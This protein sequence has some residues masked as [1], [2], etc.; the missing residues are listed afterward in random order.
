MRSLYKI[1][2]IALIFTLIRVPLINQDTKTVKRFHVAA[3]N[4][5]AEKLFVV[6]NKERL[7]ELRPPWEKVLTMLFVKEMSLAEIAAELKMPLPVI[8]QYKLAGF[9]ELKKIVD[10]NSYKNKGPIEI[11]QPAVP[12]PKR[13]GLTKQVKADP[14]LKYQ[15]VVENRN[16]LVMLKKQQK[17]VLTEL[18]KG[19]RQV[20]IAKKLGI[21]PPDV[22]RYKRTGL[23]KLRELVA[24][25]SNYNGRNLLRL[26]I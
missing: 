25:L 13:T 22:T 1:T 7:K 16:L 6:N 15:W 3:N 5:S 2:N 24:K 26:S 23:N 17:E 8:V 11:I 19:K 10:P 4:Y 20:D 12:A 9:E 21:S 14:N 18:I